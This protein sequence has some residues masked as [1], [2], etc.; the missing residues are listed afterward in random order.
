MNDDG[1][2]QSHGAFEGTIRNKL[3]ARFSGRVPGY[4][5]P[6]SMMPLAV[7]GFYPATPPKLPPRDELMGTINI[8]DSYLQMNSSSA[9]QCGESDFYDDTAIGKEGKDDQF[10]AEIPA[11]YHGGNLYDVPEAMCAVYNEEREKPPGTSECENQTLGS[12][13]L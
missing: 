10:Y 6:G 9:K 4:R 7:P 11:F 5:Q 2:L 3:Y 13:H 8:S 1:N 12:S